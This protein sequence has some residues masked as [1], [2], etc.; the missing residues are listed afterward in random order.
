M[1]ITQP[2]LFGRSSS[3]FTR[4]TRI[5]AAE[6]HV[7]YA[8]RVV[9]DLLSRDPEDYGGNPALR[10]PVLQTERGRWFGAQ[11]ICRELARSSERPLRIVWPEQLADAALSN[12]QE[13]VLQAMASEVTLVMSKLAG[14]GT[15]AHQAKLNDS[16]LNSLAWLEHAAPPALAALPERDLSY[17]EVTLYCLM[18][19]L[20]FREL[21][22]TSRYPRLHEFC[23]R[24]GRRAS[25]A[26]TPFQFDV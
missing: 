23:Q 5:F 19:H 17:L 21:A 10:L 18:T 11:N 24:F 12:V 8:F 7:D 1:P 20:S 6:L 13:L 22:D 4:V 15:D 14:P 25:A 16:L 26:A 3:H 9:R 2:T